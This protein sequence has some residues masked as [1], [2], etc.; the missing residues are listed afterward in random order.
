MK[1]RILSLLLLTTFAFSVKATNPPTYPPLPPGTRPG[2]RDYN[3]VTYSAQ[4]SVYNKQ[5]DEWEK[6]P[7]GNPP[8]H[9]ECISMEISFGH[10][11]HQSRIPSG[12]ILLEREKPS[13]SL[14]TP[15][16]LAFEFNFNSYLVGVKIAPATGISRE[17][18]IYRSNGQGI[19]YR[20][21]TGESV[22]TPI[23]SDV[24]SDSKLRMIDANGN[25]VADNPTYYER[26]SPNG[27]KV[28]FPAEQFTMAK[29]TIIDGKG[30]EIASDSTEVQ[31]EPIYRDNALRQIWSAA[32]GLADFV[33]IDDYKYEIRIYAPENAGSKNVQGLYVPQGSPFELWTIENPNRSDTDF[34]NVRISQTIAGTTY[35]YDWAYTEA[36]NAWTVTAGAGLRKAS[37][38]YFG[39]YRTANCQI[40]DE[41]RDASNNLVARK[42]SN[43]QKF[44]WKAEIVDETIDP[45]GA[46]LKTSYT[47]YT[48]STETGKYG[49]R[50]SIQKPDGSSESYNYDS[51]SRMTLK[52]ST[53][54]DNAQGKIESYSFSPLDPV[55]VLS[56]NDSR[57]RTIETKILGTTVNKK[58]AVYKTVSGEPIEIHEEGIAAYGDSSNQ[59][60]M[61]TY[62]ANSADEASKGR[63]KSITWS[64]GK[65]DTYT[66]EYG[67]Y[68][69]NPDPSSCSFAA[70]SGD[71]LR[72]TIVHG[73]S[74]NS[75]GVAG[76][77]TKEVKVTDGRSNDVMTEVYAYDGGYSR[78]AWNV[79]TFDAEHHVLAS[80]NSNGTYSTSTWNCCSKDSESS[81]DGTQYTFSYDL[82]KRLVSKTKCGVGVSPAIVTSYTYDA[83][84]RQLSESI[85]GGSALAA[86]ATSYDLAGR[87][88]S[89]TDAAGL[90]T[91][92]AYSNGGRTV[93]A[94]HPGGFT[95][96]TDK[97]IDGKI[98]SITGT[99]VVA[100]FYTYGVNI[101]GT[102][103]TKVNSGIANSPNYVKTTV[104]AL[105]RTVSEE[106]PGSTGT[107][108]TDYFYNAQ[109]L[110]T[111]VSSTGNADTLY[112][113]DDFNNQIR[114]A[115]DLN[116]NGQIDLGSD[117]RV[118]ESETTFQ[119]VSG[120]WWSVATSKVYGDNGAVVTGI[121]KK[122]LTA[123]GIAG[124]P[125]GILISKTIS[126]DINGNET[127][128]TTSLDRTGR[129]VFQAVTSPDSSISSLS[130]TVNGLLMSQRT[131]TNLTYN[132]SY[133]GIGRKIGDSD[134]RTGASVTHYNAL[135]QVD[136]VQ[137]AA[138]KQT[139][140]TYDSSSGR[141]TEV[142]NP[143]A[144]KVI[145]TYNS[146]GQISTVRGDASYPLD[147][148]Y[149]SYGRMTQLKTYRDAGLANADVTTWNYQESTGLLTSKTYADNKSVAYTYSADGKLATRTWSRG[150]VTNYAYN[151]AGDLT[152]ITYSDS[153]PAVGFTYN[154][155]GQQLTVTDAVGSRTFGYSDKFQLT[156]ETINGI[157]N[158]ILTRS[159]DTLG[160]SSGMNIG[161]EYA[162]GYGYDNLGRFSTVTNG[163]DVFTYGYLA[164]SNLIQSITYPSTISVTKSY[165]SNRD[166][167]TSIENKYGTT[168]ISKYDYSN[169]DLGR[170]TAMG[171]S[172]TAFTQADTIAYGY[173]DKSEVTSAVAQNQA[174]YN[175]GFNFDLI[176]NRLSS[177]T[178]ET[179]TS[180]TRNYTSNQLNQYT[181]IDT[182][183][184]SPTYDFDGNML[185]DGT[186][187]FTWNGENR[188]ITA[189][190]GTTVI[191]YKYDYF[192]RRV[193]RKVTEGGTVTSNVRYVYEQGSFNKVEELDVLNSSAIAKKYVWGL[194]IAGSQTVTGS[195]GALLAQIDGTGTAY[196]TLDAN[197]NVSEYLNAS[198]TIQGHFEYAPFGKANVENGVRA[199]DF[200]F[201]FSTKYEDALTGDL[202]YGLRDYDSK[203]GRWRSRDP[204]E[205]NGSVNLFLACNND[206]INEVD[207]LGLLT[208]CE[209]VETGNE[210]KKR[211]ACYKTKFI[212]KT[213]Y[214]ERQSISISIG[215]LGTGE[216]ETLIPEG[217]MFKYIWHF[218]M[219]YA[220]EREVKIYKEKALICCGLCLWTYAGD[221]IRTEK[222][223]CSDIKEEK[224]VVSG[225]TT[226]PNV[227]TYPNWPNPDNETDPPPRGTW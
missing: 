14:F 31:V 57:P 12:T 25:P 91:T 76:K 178:S 122:Q 224:T 19:T 185:N 144:K 169:D 59:R 37:K 52:T 104:D 223:K 56:E 225:G 95:E 30:Q 226:N 111:K 21:K 32:S 166:L 97:Y 40:V 108:V 119:S 28:R 101:D 163:A 146:R 158:K 179:G 194:D 195:V 215:N 167:V 209:T 227:P 67:T 6:C 161:T 147:Y 140:F 132:Y 182:P 150:V 135:G 180:V 82:L 17:A 129:T 131:S 61:A 49:K 159:Y 113:Y 219:Y 112:A 75:T 9:P 89:R 92:Y 121:S 117:D 193:E 100:K 202:D 26:L 213:W 174:T 171:K 216:S 60:V 79:K 128:S 58:Y 48:T 176:G 172:G 221:L 41:A 54:L 39:D 71:A 214:V 220:A 27:S 20:F 47:Y 154:R 211:G 165:E 191:D 222:E 127:V 87:V 188:I 5:M 55:D 107:L 3:A 148:V 184:T 151:T 36:S 29:P 187:S 51:Q 99:A 125:A 34:N 196:S 13:A 64:N 197:G 116:A 210:V 42:V 136:Y 126:I 50:K 83:E 7:C 114:S 138:G 22:A 170:R 217:F 124:T 106:R 190:Q 35:V 115:L 203:L 86:T 120:Q 130:T 157:Y 11:V 103:W 15:Q 200:A 208:C 105:G 173:N 96:I 66:Y 10:P 139:S 183:A 80:Y 133:D 2:E 90:I 201:R 143:F 44:A 177:T 156:S 186:W 137:D 123:L 33:I 62:Y 63:I 153:T 23:S 181:A 70:G 149:D 212:G 24:A 69:A 134:P 53:Y 155:L 94:T 175:Y 199:D 8:V 85:S 145:Y 74:A 4:M 16:S 73:T 205:E 168:T 142:I 43:T 81:A 110:L 162:V 46:N 164:N 93:T 141:R 45:D 152:G 84:G 198:G 160:R 109:G 204:S 189:T 118:S 218:T 192:G 78:I 68:S 207:F 88:T 38:H 206:T 1:T 65:M 72:E 18:T 98:K 102:Q 77:S